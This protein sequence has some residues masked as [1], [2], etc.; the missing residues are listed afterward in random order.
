METREFKETES[1]ISVKPA[2]RYTKNYRKNL[3]IFSLQ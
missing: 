1:V 3:I 2:K